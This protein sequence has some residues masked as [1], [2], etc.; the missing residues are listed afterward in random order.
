MKGYY[1]PEGAEGIHS[2]YE[3]L[4]DL[5]GPLED[6]NRDLKI[7]LA[8]YKRAYESIVQLHRSLN[9]ALVVRSLLESVASL[10]F[11]ESAAVIRFE[12]GDRMRVLGGHNISKQRVEEILDQAKGM[13]EEARF[14]RR[15]VIVAD[16]L[17]ERGRHLTGRELPS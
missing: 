8:K 6:L 15:P 7:D 11:I 3:I 17:K 16:A 4:K 1:Y 12:P 5:I 13:V 2:D 14:T 9:S 10:F